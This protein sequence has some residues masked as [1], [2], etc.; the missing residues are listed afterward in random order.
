MNQ[1]L[2]QAPFNH[3]QV[4]E[5]FTDDRIVGAKQ[6]VHRD[7]GIVED[8]RRR[9]RTASAIVKSSKQRVASALDAIRGN[10]NENDYCVDSK[11]PL[12]TQEPTFQGKSALE[13]KKE[14]NFPL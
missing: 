1:T 3:Q 5:Q 10:I 12:P 7:G 4:V 9:K 8:P 13:I 2:Q 6:I 14:S 11:R